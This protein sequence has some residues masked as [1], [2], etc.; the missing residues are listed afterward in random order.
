M[1]VNDMCELL[2]GFFELLE[3]IM[4]YYWVLEEFNF[5]MLVCFL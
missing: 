4:S 1:C 2:M 5:K 3:N